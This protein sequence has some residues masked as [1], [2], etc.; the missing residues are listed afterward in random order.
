MEAPL[1]KRRKLSAEE[2]DESIAKPVDDIE[3]TALSQTAS[4]GVAVQDF[5]D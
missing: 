2:E 5:E 4:D 1:S 3:D